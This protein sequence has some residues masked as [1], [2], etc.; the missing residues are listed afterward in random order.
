MLATKHYGYRPQRNEH[1]P[2]R[3]RHDPLRVSAKS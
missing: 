3:Q 1:R 2:G